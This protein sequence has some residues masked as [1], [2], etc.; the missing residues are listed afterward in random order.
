MISTHSP[1]LLCIP[2]AQVYEL[3]REEDQLRQVN[4]RETQLFRLYSGFLRSPERVM[5][6]LLK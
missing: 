3:S 4:Y 2:G 6:E 5:R 1:I